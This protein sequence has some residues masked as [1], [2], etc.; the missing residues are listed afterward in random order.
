VVAIGGDGTLREV[1]S[2]LVDPAIPVGLLPLGTANVLSLDLG[3]PHDVDGAIEVLCAR[4]TA[5]IDMF[6][7]NGELGFL[8]AGVGFDG[9]AVHEVEA[10]RC[11]AIAKSHYVSAGL[12]ALRNYREPSLEVEIDGRRLDGRFGWVL[13]SN[14]IHYAGVVRLSS[15]RALDDGL[16]EVYLFRR[17][18][19]LRLLLHGLRGLAGRLPGGG[20]ELVRA[21]RISVRSES[22]VPV[23][24]DGDARGATPLE[25]EVTGRQ[26]QLLIP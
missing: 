1:F 7:A 12:R 26:F 15:E 21:R 11:G 3:L 9:A 23:Q 22:P 20:C 5:A 4:K 14:I 6:T 19:R 16:L 25:I 10:R 17:A 2:G 24:V 18:D 8:V 13:A